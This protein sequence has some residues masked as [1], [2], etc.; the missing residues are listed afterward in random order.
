[1]AALVLPAP[2]SLLVPPAVADYRHRFFIKFSMPIFTSGERLTPE[3]GD[4]VRER[5]RN[6]R[7]GVIE[8]SLEES[9]DC[10]GFRLRTPGDS[11]AKLNES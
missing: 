3:C 5:E 2:A 1:V 8:P 7:S 4:E 10:T 11:F 9:A 6:H